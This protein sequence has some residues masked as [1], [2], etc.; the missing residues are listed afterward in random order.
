[1]SRQKK[2]AFP[3]INLA[4]GYGAARTGKIFTQAIEREI[5]FTSTDKFND[6]ANDEKVRAAVKWLKL[7]IN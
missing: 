4:I 2:T 5:P 7:H 3:S 6:G 1:M